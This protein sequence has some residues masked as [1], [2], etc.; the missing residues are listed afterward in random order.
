[1]LADKVRN[2][3]LQ[4]WEPVYGKGKTAQ[5]LE[6]WSK[7]REMSEF[8][9]AQEITSMVFNA[10]DAPTIESILHSPLFNRLTPN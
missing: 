9:H 3:F 7:A 4:P 10:N 8:K 1:M 6:R 5:V 2:K